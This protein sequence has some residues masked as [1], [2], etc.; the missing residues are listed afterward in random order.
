MRGAPNSFTADAD[1]IGHGLCASGPAASAEGDMRFLRL[2][3]V[4]GAPPYKWRPSNPANWRSYSDR[5]RWLVTPNDAF[6]TANYHD[7]YVEHVD[8]IVQPL[9]AATLSGSFHP[10][11]LGHAALAIPFWLNCVKCWVRSRIRI[12][13]NCQMDDLSDRPFP[14]VSRN[15]CRAKIAWRR[16]DDALEGTTERCFRF[17][18]KPACNDRDLQAVAKRHCFA[19]CIRNCAT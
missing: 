5:T 9:Y 11:A 8:D 13:F 10:N 15:R 6:L 1:G 2:P 7:A 17:I 3:D 19:S 14:V 18:S 4:P 16:A 12:A